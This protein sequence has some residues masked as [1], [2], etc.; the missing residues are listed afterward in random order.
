MIILTSPI[1]I[2]HSASSYVLDRMAQKLDAKILFHNQR[3]TVQTVHAI[4]EMCEGM[5]ISGDSLALQMAA[6]FRNIGY[7]EDCKDPL[8]ASIEILHDFTKQENIDSF[9]FEEARLGILATKN[10]EEGHGLKEAVM[11][12]A[13]WYFL[14]ASNHLEMCDRLHEEWA[15][16]GQ[17]WTNSEWIEFVNGLYKKGL[18]VSTYGRQVLE[19]RKQV[20]YYI[21]LNRLYGTAV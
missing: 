12:D 11:H 4:K 15:N 6:W 19:K 10:L 18:Y 7:T 5:S 21:F 13:Y 16:L 3:H 1:D 14:S 20:N 8:N 17:E 2:I 9:D